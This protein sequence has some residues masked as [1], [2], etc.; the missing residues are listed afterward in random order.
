ML[1]KGKATA[2]LSAAARCPSSEATIRGH[3]RWGQGRATPTPLH[4]G[5]F[6]G[7]SACG[8]MLV[9]RDCVAVPG[10]GSVSPGI[11]EMRLMN[12]QSNISIANLRELL[13]QC[14]ETELLLQ[15]M[16]RGKKGAG[17][18]CRLP[19]AVGT[20]LWLSGTLPAPECV[21]GAGPAGGSQGGN[22]EDS[23]AAQTLSQGLPM[24]TMRNGPRIS[25]TE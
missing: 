8:A 3:W 5:F 23:P 20:L 24:E 7:T 11:W 14:P 16:W 15:D 17:A 18:Q 12:V 25:P 9:T 13:R 22:P 10:L 21:S 19:R 6:L 2:L 1:S 4:P